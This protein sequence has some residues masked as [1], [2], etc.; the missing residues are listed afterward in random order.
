MDVKGPEI[1][2]SVVEAHGGVVA[3]EDA[4][5]GGA[6]IGFQLPRPTSERSIG[7]GSDTDR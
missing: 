4:P 6:R 7:I 2:A 1:V 3:V 5:D